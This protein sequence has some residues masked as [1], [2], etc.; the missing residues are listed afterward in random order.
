MFAPLPAP[1]EMSGWDR[2]AIALGI[3][4]PMLMENASREALHALIEETGDVRGKRILLFMG[5]G[6]NGGD[7]ACLARHLLD[8]GADVLV[9]HT[10]PLSACR[11]TTGMHLRLARRCGV[12]FAPAM[13][14]PVRYRGTPWD[15][16]ADA[17]VC[18][19]GGPD[20]VV[21]GLLGTGF[22]GK[23]RPLER[24]LVNHINAL[25]QRAFLFSL[26]IPSGLSGL[27]GRPGP[28]AVCAH[29]TVTFE[30]AKPGLVLPE[31]SS[32]VGKLHI[33]PI[34]IPARVRRTL[35][36]SFQMLTE[37]IA[38]VLPRP[39]SGW[40]KGTAGSVLI[41][42]GSAGLTG[43][44]HLAALAALR[45]GAGL[46]SIA[47][48]HGLCR[49]IKADCPDLMTRPLGP[50]GGTSWSPEL[51]N[52][53]QAYLRHCHALILGPGLG[54]TPET[55]AFVQALLACPSRPSAIVDADALHALAMRPEAL[56]SLRSCDI[57]TPHP[58][59]AAT[60][61]HAT[62]ALVQADRFE[63][64]TSLQRLAPSVWILKG[65]GTLI[66]TPGQPITIAPY[67]EPNLAV[68][69]SGD[70]LSGCLGTLMA[71]TAPVPSDECESSSFLAACLGVYLHARAGHLLRERFPQRGNSA[72][73]IAEALPR[74]RG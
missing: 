30:A 26:D 55:A 33:R 38:G 5:G 43:A 29:A 40:H 9:L 57:L 51:L 21:D 74:V 37:A 4:E 17:T 18:E 49:D 66:A 65:A 22:S 28:I 41:V 59:E 48:P 50:A 14:W 31:A 70:V 13:G 73:E 58:G 62:P 54:R 8:Q 27:T 36:A 35:P 56:A 1:A 25:R 10:R 24:D 34:G 52:E 19:R 20:I 68:G 47:A 60:L 7:A 15:P 16:Y 23:L 39:T 32:F 45:T 61:L 11:G 53:L 46:I 2:A 3:P 72:S 69:G 67:A 6:N 71:Q 63:T 12:P 42:G 44:P 64:I